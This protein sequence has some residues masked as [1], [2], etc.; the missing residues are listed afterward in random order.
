MVNHE[1]AGNPANA[2]SQRL[3][4]PNEAATYLSVGRT[5]VY[6][7]MDSGELPFITV[8]TRRRLIREDLDRFIAARQSARAAAATA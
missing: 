7:L 3:F 6:A 1:H 5:T 2:V 4:A 8:G